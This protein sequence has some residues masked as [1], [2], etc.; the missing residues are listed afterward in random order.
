MVNNEKH[1]VKRA[2]I[3]AAGMGNRLHPVTLKTPKPLVKVNG[4]RIID[5]VISALH[6]NSIK[7]IYIVTG[8][9]KINSIYLKRN[10]LV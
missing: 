1:M 3:M 7:D 9:L 10:I 8:Y 2:I 6:E 4:T 5:T